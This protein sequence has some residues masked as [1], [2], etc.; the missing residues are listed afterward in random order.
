MRIMIAVLVLAFFA[1]T[2]VQARVGESF[3]QCVKRYGAPVASNAKLFD[4]RTGMEIKQFKKEGVPV[5]AIFNGDKAVY[6]EYDYRA[7]KLETGE[8]ASEIIRQLLDANG[9]DWKA[10]STANNRDWLLEI[11]D[12]EG[13]IASDKVEPGFAKDRWICNGGPEKGGFIAVKSKIS[14]ILIIVNS[15]YMDLVM[16][17]Q[18]KYF[19][20]RGEKVKKALDDF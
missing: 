20:E 8:K 3:D 16:K 18:P 4:Q 17:N 5:K 12:D 6:V 14:G 15:E 11:N 9:R 2:G 7:L 1:A 19:K 10:D 13:V